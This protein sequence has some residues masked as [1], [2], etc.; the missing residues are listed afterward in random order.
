MEVVVSCCTGL[1]AALC[2]AGILRAL[3]ESAARGRASRAAGV[4]GLAER[5][6][7][8]LGGCGLVASGGLGEAVLEVGRLRVRGREPFSGIDAQG[9][10]GATALMGA[11]SAVAACAVSG[12]VA[13]API[14]FALPAAGAAAAGA[15]RRRRERAR[16]EEA[17]PEAFGALAVSLGSGYSL[18]QAMRY[19]GSHAEEPVRTEFMRVS[20]AVDCGVP[21]VEALDAMLGRLRAPGLDLVVLAL[22]VSQRTGAPLGELLAEASRSV[23]ERI[24]L[25][26]RLDVK[27]SQARMSARMVACMP[28]AMTAL[29]SL[30][31]PD[32]RSGLATPAGAGSVAVA[33]ALNAVAW[34]S[35]RKIMDVE[36]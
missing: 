16:L 18:P 9:A 15:A 3:D 19:V 35:I 30:L 29:L 22:K 36:L 11:C 28:M 4:R 13:A 2:V 33:L 21:A 7:A 14:G 5:V 17:M 26:R 27:T 34:G 20:F 25:R 12:S 10:L 24:E 6:G 32:F 31:S 1:L 8:A 23:G